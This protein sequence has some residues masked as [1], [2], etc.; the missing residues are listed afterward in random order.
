VETA[1]GVIGN[2]ASIKLRF[3][4]AYMAMAAEGK[5]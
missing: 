5:L 2:S 1:G 3:D 4:P